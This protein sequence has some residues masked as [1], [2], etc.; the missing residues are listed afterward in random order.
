[1]E[2][3]I[4]EKHRKQQQRITYSLPVVIPSPIGENGT[5]DFD[6]IEKKYAESC[7]LPTNLF[8]RQQMFY[9]SELFAD[10][11]DWKQYKT[12]EL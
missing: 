6:M 1:M 10:K 8:R 2:T 9:Y 5:L 3:L 12:I 4:A 7:L 11:K